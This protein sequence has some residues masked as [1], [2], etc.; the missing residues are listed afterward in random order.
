MVQTIDINGKPEGKPTFGVMACDSYE[1]I[2]NDI[3]PTLD[4]LNKAVDEAGDLLT[5]ADEGRLFDVDRSKIGTQENFYGKE[6]D[7]L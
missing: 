1:Q 2:Y 7:Y 3:Y 6:K 5:V 4:E